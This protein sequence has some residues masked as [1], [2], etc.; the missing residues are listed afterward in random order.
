M[1]TLLLKFYQLGLDLESSDE[2]SPD[3]EDD[4]SSTSTA[5]SINTKVKDGDQYTTSW[6][7]MTKLDPNLLLYKA[8]GARNLPVMIE[9]LS[10]RADPNWVNMDEEGR[11]PIMKAVQTVI[12]KV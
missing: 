9:A 1:V 3:L 5:D 2:S 4:G 12:I 8:S 10:N 6:E 11:T 7:D